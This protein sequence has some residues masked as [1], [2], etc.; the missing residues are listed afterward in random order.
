MFVK[1][2]LERKNLVKEQFSNTEAAESISGTLT[3]I[4]RI[5]QVKD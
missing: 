2:R 5:N 1:L 3:D 4:T